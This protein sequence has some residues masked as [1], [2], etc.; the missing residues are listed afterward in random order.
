MTQIVVNKEL[1]SRLE[2]ASNFAALCD[3]SGN[4]LGYYR[5]ARKA[6]GYRNPIDGSPFAEEEVQRRL[7]ERGGRPLA[8]MLQELRAS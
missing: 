8:E 6:G 1:Q 7:R 4:T 5:P 2:A 3:E